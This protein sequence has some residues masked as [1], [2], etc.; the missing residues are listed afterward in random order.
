MIL[1]D[2]WWRDF[3]SSSKRLR[4]R[5]AEPCL[6]GRRALGRLRCLGSDP[7]RLP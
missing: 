2:L 6:R 5:G 1:D 3:D 4:D 7:G